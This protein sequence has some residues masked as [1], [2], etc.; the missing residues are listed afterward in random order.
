MTHTN[1]KDAN[2]NQ[3]SKE[4]K[5][6]TTEDTQNRPRKRKSIRDATSS[7]GPLWLPAD[8]IPGYKLYWAKV[9]ASNPY[10]LHQLMEIGWGPLSEEQKKKLI[11]VIPTGLLVQTQ[12]EFGSWITKNSG[13]IVHYLMCMPLDIVDEINK[14]KREIR[15]ER[16]RGHVQDIK[17]N[18]ILTSS[19]ISVRSNPVKTW[20]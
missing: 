7:K 16:E 2:T 20:D 4:T 10:K 5:L 13:E 18:S 17:N 19:D 12:T 11:G 9:S 14:E 1:G 15:E 6:M 3:L 8:L